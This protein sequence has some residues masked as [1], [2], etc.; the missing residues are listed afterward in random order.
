M[1]VVINTTWVKH[2]SNAFIDWLIFLTIIKQFFIVQTTQNI[3]VIL[4]MLCLDY[5]HAC[6]LKYYLQILF[7]VKPIVL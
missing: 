5:K 7:F 6:F 4:I 3:P 2:K 1:V